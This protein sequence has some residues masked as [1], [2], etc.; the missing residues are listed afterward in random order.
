MEHT[1]RGPIPGPELS[2]ETLEREL[3]H[4]HETERDVQDRSEAAQENHADRT[5][6]LEV[7][8]DRRDMG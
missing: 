1:P 2:D 8:A 4:L 5:A 3:T 6:E 7:E